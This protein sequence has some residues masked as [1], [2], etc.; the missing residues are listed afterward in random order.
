MTPWHHKRGNSS[1]GIA[2]QESL[3]L[4]CASATRVLVSAA[5]SKG[6]IVGVAN[7]FEIA[8][9]ATLRCWL[10]MSIG[11]RKHVFFA[12]GRSFDLRKKAWR[13]KNNGA[14]RCLNPDCPSF[15]F[16]R[17]I[18]GRDPQAAVAI[19]LVG[20]STMIL[21]SPFEPFN[22]R[23]ASFSIIANN[24]WYCLPVLAVW[25]LVLCFFFNLSQLNFLISVN[26]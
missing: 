16:G 15:I 19:A 4:S 12:S 6:L 23:H 7:G 8:M 13:K 17:A 25:L 14:S 22:P 10:L 1:C 18:Q 3:C 24:V 21:K 20:I 2:S 26:P 11:L 9:P 5:Q